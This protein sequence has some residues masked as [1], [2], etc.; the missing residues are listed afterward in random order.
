MTIA[1]G[2]TGGGGPGATASSTTGAQTW[3]GQEKSTLAGVLANLAAS[4]SITVYAADG[5]GAA[6]SSI[7]GRLCRSDRPHRHAHLHRAGRRDAE[8]LAHRR[9]AVGLDS[10][11]RPL[12][13]PGSRRRSVGALSVSGQTI[14]DYRRHAHRRPDRRRHVRL[15]RY[16]DRLCGDR[17]A[18]LADPGELD[19][20][21]HPHLD[22][23]VTCG[24]R[25]RERRLGNTRRSDVECLRVAGRQHDRLH[26]H[27]RDWRHE[28]RHASRSSCRQAGAHRRRS[29]MPPATR[30]RAREPSPPRARRSP[31]PR[32]RSR[33]ARPSPITYGSKA[34]GGPGATAT[35]TTG[36]QT[37]QGQERSTAAGALTNLGASPSITVNA[38][39]GSGTMTVLPANAGNGS[40]GNTLTFT[41]TAAAGG[42][43]TAA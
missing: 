38:A 8:R 34:G 9:R 22:R 29:P 25:L 10:R 33:A 12:P 2:D 17:H 30:R 15:G 42:W 3:Q 13:A 28:R 40:T 7:S 26:V 4:P 19:R 16:G 5:A 18:D 1:Y 37:W 20:R 31:S 43:R 41:Y 6:T 27:R 36:T 11:R 21:G 32:S 14:T 39:N 24:H 23:D 35:A